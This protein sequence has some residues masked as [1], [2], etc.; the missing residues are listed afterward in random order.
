[1]SPSTR[2]TPTRAGA[3]ARWLRARPVRRSFYNRG[4]DLVAREL[5]GCVLVRRHGRGLLTGRIVETEAYEG[6]D[7]RA[8]HASRGRT[9]R[10]A[11]MYGDP[12][13][14]Y[15]YFIY[16]VYDMLNV[17]CQPAGVPEAVLIRG[18]EPL[19]GVESMLRRRG[20]R[21]LQDVAS[22]PG[23]LCRAF[24]ITRK[25]NGADLAGP[26][27]WITSGRLRAN[28]A[29][30]TSARIGVDYAGGDAHRPLRFFIAGNLNV[31]R[32]RVSAA[33]SRRRLT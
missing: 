32:P 5:L 7:D 30:A 3:G 22:G 11:V 26:G 20:V 29:I 15:V 12:G 8:C 21:R 10:N 25:Q 31:S 16:G 2:S 6:E 24:S 33:A 28:E 1:M 14:A 4:A 23:K 13:H 9:R 19:H 17:V 27:L 18:I